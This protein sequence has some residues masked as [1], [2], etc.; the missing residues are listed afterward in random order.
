MPRLPELPLDA[1][2]AWERGRYLGWY[3]FFILSLLS[4]SLFFSR[5][6]K[7]VRSCSES[8]G[9]T[10]CSSPAGHQLRRHEHLDHPVGYHSRRGELRRDFLPGWVLI[11]SLT[12]L[13]HPK[14]T[15]IRCARNVEL[16]GAE[17][18]WRRG[19]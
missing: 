12:F 16:V 11:L 4:P 14:L 15:Q 13:L 18:F 3:P 10:H 2:D 17:G 7:L 5:A 19:E 6:L 1:W 8:T 9:D